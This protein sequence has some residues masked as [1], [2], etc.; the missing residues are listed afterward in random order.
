VDG[1]AVVPNAG[2]RW[3]VT[4]R[5]ALAAAY[6]GA[7]SF[8]RTTSVCNLKQQATLRDDYLICLSAVAPLASSTE[9]LPDAW[10]AGASF[11]AT[12]RLRLVAEGV[13]RHYT[14]LA[15][16]PYTVLGH[17]GRAPYNDV[18][19]LHAGVEYRL[20]SVALRAGWWRDPS[21]F[22]IV[23][24]YGQTVTHYTFGAGIGVGRA[25]LDLAYDYASLA[26]QRRAVAGITFGL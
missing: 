2:L 15:D 17:A 16:D 9:R 24:N 12:E 14:K 8:T 26:M 3:R 11:A 7:G 21:R 20:R 19:E 4:P 18:T 13:R 5:I 25:R 22:D 6:N 10:R 23:P 1:R